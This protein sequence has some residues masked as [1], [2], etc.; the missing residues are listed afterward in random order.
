MTTVFVPTDLLFFELNREDL[1]VFDPKLIPLIAHDRAGF[2]GA[3]LSEGFL[4]LCISL[5]GFREGEKWIWWTFFIG[6]LPGF[7]AGIGTHFHIGYTDFVHL[8]PAYFLVVLF[9]VGLIYSFNYLHHCQT[10]KSKF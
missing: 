2:G 6:G 10:S 1:N 7:T 5:W 3:L 4:L 8:L 9:I